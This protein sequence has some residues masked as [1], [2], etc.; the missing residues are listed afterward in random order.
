M[1]CSTTDRS[2]RRRC[3]SRDIARPELGWKPIHWFRSQS[4]S[5][6]ENGKRSP[7]SKL[8]PM[9]SIKKETYETEVEFNALQCNGTIWNPNPVASKIKTG[10]PKPVASS[11]GN[12]K[13]K[14]N[15]LPKLPPKPKTEIS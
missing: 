11:Y 1:E 5:L 3:L 13:Q 7:R 4:Q 2:I 9:A 10:K 8:K 14:V 6:V 12:T 15:P